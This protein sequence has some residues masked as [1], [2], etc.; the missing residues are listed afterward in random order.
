MIKKIVFIGAN[1]KFKRVFPAISFF[2]G[3]LF[4]IVT[5]DR[6]DQG[7]TLAQQAIWLF[8]IG[9][10]LFFKI[11]D[12][13][14]PIQFNSSAQKLFERIWSYRFGLIHFLFGGLLSAYMIFYFK[15][16]SSWISLIFL[17]IIAA[18]LVANEM[19]R[20][21]KYGLI[22]QSVLF[23]LCLVS[24][25]AYLF[26]IL[27]GK[28]QSWVFY[29]SILVSVAVVLGFSRLL[30]RYVQKKS[31]EREFLIPAGI[32]QI[33]FLLFFWFNLIPPVPLSLKSIG[34]YH[35]VEREGSVYRAYHENPWWRFWQSADDHF[36]AHEGD[37]I[38][39]FTQ[40]FAPSYFNDK[41]YLR[42]YHKDSKQGWVHWDRIP[43]NIVGGRSTGYRGYAYKNNYTEGKWQVRIETQDG[44]EVGRKTFYVQKESGTVDIKGFDEF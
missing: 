11:I 31:V 34:I 30:L 8:L 40:I 21:R 2:A 41:I 39:C 24:Y 15:S 10:I 38:Y 36:I 3:L 14:S 44:R 22:I 12:A 5:T 1:S 29:L 6:I 42:W 25:L 20:F 26:P 9:L 23:S 17:G 43:L 13:T 7:F 16:S 19:E 27:V 28:L 33:L 37:S 4:D 35:K 18:V 32:V